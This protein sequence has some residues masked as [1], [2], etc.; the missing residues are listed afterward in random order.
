MT[1]GEFASK[2]GYDRAVYSKWEQG[3]NAPKLEFLYRFEKENGI[4]LVDLVAIGGGDVSVA[5]MLEMAKVQDFDLVSLIQELVKKI[6][7]LETRVAELEAERDK[8]GRNIFPS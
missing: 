6:E 1:Q 7:A 4:S 5:Q 2:Y 8:K 3:V